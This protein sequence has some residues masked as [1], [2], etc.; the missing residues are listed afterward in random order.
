MRSDVQRRTAATGFELRGSATG[1]TLVG[2]AAV[3]DTEAVIAGLFRETIAPGSFRKS[4]READVRALFN[5]DPNYVLGRNKAGT[6]RLAE[7]GRGLAYEIDLP[8]TAIARDLYTSIERGDI[9]QSSFAFKVVREKR[10]EPAKNETLPLFTVQEAKLFDV[11][12]VTYPA[13]DA[14]DVSAASDD[15]GLAVA[16]ARFAAFCGR[17]P[18]EVMAFLRAHPDDDSEQLRG[19]WTKVH[20]GLSRVRDVLTIS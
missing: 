12:P 1:A 19:L 8:D 20:A 6:L 5:H 16:V 9:S 4:I 7:D 2:H 10:A 18:D 11:S 17:P 15:V 14:T 3:F 13:Y